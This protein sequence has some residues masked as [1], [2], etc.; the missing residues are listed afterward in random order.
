M[1][2][3]RRA[4]NVHTRMFDDELVLLDLDGGDYFALNELGTELWAGLEKGETLAQIAEG[5]AARHAVAP[6]RALTDLLALCD[7]LVA[8]KLLVHERG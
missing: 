1:D 6:D 3:Y 8:R 7:E 4:T 5:I 2:R